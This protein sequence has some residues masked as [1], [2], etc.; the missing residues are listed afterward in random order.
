[1]YIEIS[2]KVAISGWWFQP[3]E[4]YESQLGCFFP[5]EWKNKNHVPN[6]Q[7]VNNIG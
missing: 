3:S 6:H 4:Q 1:M 7:P 2:S 5:I